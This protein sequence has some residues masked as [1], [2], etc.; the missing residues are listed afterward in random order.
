MRHRPWV[1]LGSATAPSGL[2][3]TIAEEFDSDD[4]FHWD[5]IESGVEFGDSS[6]A[7]ESNKDVAFYPSCTHVVVEA[8]L[9]VFAP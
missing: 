1:W 6:I 2:V 9:P 3:V 7:H 4:E 8:I 5:G